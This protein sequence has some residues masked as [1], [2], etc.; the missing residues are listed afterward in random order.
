MSLLHNLPGCF[1]EKK[2]FR[3]NS[4]SLTGEVKHKFP[5]RTEKTK[6]QYES[7]VKDIIFSN[8]ANLRS[9]SY[10][11]VANKEA[12]ERLSSKFPEVVQYIEGPHLVGWVVTY[13]SRSPFLELF[14]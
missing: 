8:F 2:Q 11:K 6:T 5:Y 3:D 13:V 9:L 14:R 1:T 12:D 4:I 10:S 7:A